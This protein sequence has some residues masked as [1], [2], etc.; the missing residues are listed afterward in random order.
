[1]DPNDPTTELIRAVRQEAIERVKAERK[2]KKKEEQAESMRM[3]KERKKKEVAL[4]SL[5]S[6]SGSMQPPSK[7]KIA[8]FSCGGNHKKSECPHKRRFSGGDD[9]P[10]R[11]IHKTKAR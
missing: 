3:A 6:L 7:N 1:L 11:K 8:C 9:G 4:N 2:A 5:T 10:P